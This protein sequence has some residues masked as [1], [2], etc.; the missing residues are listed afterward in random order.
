MLNQFSFVRNAQRHRQGTGGR[1]ALGRKHTV[2]GSS[3]IALTA[4]FFLLFIE[5]TKNCSQCRDPNFTSKEE[6]DED[7]NDG[8]DFGLDNIDYD[9]MNF[10]EMEMYPS[11]MYDPNEGPDERWVGF[12]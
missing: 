10:Y 9:N 2:A 8:F 7:Y 6:D 1:G 5:M 12:N 4:T 3:I 11:P